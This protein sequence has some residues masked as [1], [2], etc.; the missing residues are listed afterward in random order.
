ML[1]SVRLCL[2]DG[3]TTTLSP[4]DIIGRMA[5]A[6][7]VLDD[8]R[9][10]EC[11]AL[12][13]LRGAELQLL[14]LRGMFAV[15]GEPA[16][17]VALREG[18]VLSFAEGL[19]LSVEAVQLPQALAALGGDGLPLQVLGG[20]SSLHV[21]PPPRLVPGTARDAD[22]WLWSTGPRWRLRCGEAPPRDLDL[23][24][25]FELGARRFMLTTIQVER[26][27]V[28]ATVAL[29]GVGEPLVL[30]AGWDTFQI[31]R[32]GRP[33]I[34][35]GGLSARLL[36]LLAEVE[37]SLSWEG[38]A[39]ELWPSDADRDSLRRRLDVAMVRL[40]ARLRAS[41]IR[42]DLVRASGSGHLELV[43][44]PGDVVTDRS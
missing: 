33:P 42:T 3:R 5:A 7:L 22:A 27:G 30:L 8:P 4:G 6:S 12:V 28:E 32:P 38:L 2:P 19:E 29:G 34:V 10:S 40:R 31:T 23:G 16:T 17:K 26:A 15:N 25:S 36:S 39:R 37:T 24:E 21:G 41:G 14:A 11:H 13:S 43:R 35:I 20:S 44:Y 18:Q 9:V 1:V